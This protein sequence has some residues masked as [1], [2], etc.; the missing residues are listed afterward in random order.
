MTKKNYYLMLTFEK[1]KYSVNDLTIET[2]E[3][4]KEL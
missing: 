4:I 1:T 3:I 2:K